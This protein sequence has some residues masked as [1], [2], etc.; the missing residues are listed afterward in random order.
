MTFTFTMDTTPIFGLI[1]FFSLSSF[2]VVITGHLMV[3]LEGG[4]RL[5]ISVAISD[6]TDGL[7]FLCVTEYR[8]VY[9]TRVLDD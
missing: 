4:E 8:I 7:D 2:V 3:Y 5:S 1:L 6:S 9:R